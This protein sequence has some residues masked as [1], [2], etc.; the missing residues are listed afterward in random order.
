[1]P[2]GAEVGVMRAAL[3]RRVMWGLP[4]A[5]MGLIATT[6][7]GLRPDAGAMRSVLLP[8]F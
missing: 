7:A 5:Q 4:G 3:V 8:P 2:V 6:S 1:M